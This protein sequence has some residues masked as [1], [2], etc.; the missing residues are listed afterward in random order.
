MKAHSEP[1]KPAMLGVIG[2]E[3]FEARFEPPAARWRA[4]TTGASWAMDDGVP[5]VIETAFGWC[6]EARQS[7]RL[8]TGVNWSPGIVNPFRQLGR[9]GESLDTVLAKQRAG[10]RRAGDPGRCTSPARVSNTPT[11]AS[12]AVVTVMKAAAIID[13]VEG[14]TKKWAKQRK[15][16]ERE[17]SADPQPAACVVRPRASV[18]IKEAAWAV[19][20][21]AYLK[22]SAGGTLPANA[23]QIMYAARPAHPARWR[24]GSRQGLRQVF[25][26]DAA[27]RLHRGERASTGT[28][29]SMPAATSPS[30]TRRRG[31][32]RDLAGPRLP[33]ARSRTTRSAISTSTSGSSAI[34]RSGRRT[35]SARS[36]TSRR[37]ASRRCSRRCGW[38]SATTS[39]SCPP[40]ACRSRP[41][42][43]WCRRSASSTTCRSTCCTTSTSPASRSSARCAAAP[44]AS[45]TRKPF[46]VIDLGLRL[47]DIDGLDDRGCLS[48][49]AGQGRGR[50]SASTARPRTRSSSCCSS[51]SS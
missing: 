3:H 48:S 15:R 50:P 12:R 32:A 42:G 46:K 35:A 13:A 38:P 33:R 11:A 49:L 29:S 40:R 34:R 4:S 39:R 37:R 25:H 27:A 21:E 2:R 5:W 19:M 1:V 45:A 36:S 14:V 41:A 44:G 51:A 9:F 23:R 26:A 6:P 8:V 7:R 16:E 18:S 17:A 43:S 28:S 20:E 10:R 24:P 22:A 31:A 47:D 30:R